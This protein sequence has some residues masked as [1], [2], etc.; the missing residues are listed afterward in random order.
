MAEATDRPQIPPDA[1]LS[2]E[3]LGVPPPTPTQTYQPLS[4]LA[5][6]GFGLA[7]VYALVVLI[8]GAVSLLSHKPWLMPYWTF[9]L[10]IAVLF[11]SW[12][13]RTRILNSEGTLSGLAFTTWG[14]RLAIFLSI[15]YAAYLFA[16]F[17]A[18]RGSAIDCANDFFQ[19]I[20][21]G[22]LEEAFL[23][24]QENVSIKGLDASAMRDLIEARFN[25][26]SGAVAITP[27]N[28]TRFRQENFI[29]LIEM[30]GDKANVTPTGVAFWEYGKGGYRVVL[31]YHV[32]TSLVEFDMKVDTF[33][34]DPKPGESKPRQWQVLLARSETGTI[35]NSLTRTK[36]GEEFEKQSIN[37]QKFAA[38]WA[39]KIE[40]AKALKPAQRESY[41]KLIRGYETFWASD[42]LRKEISETIRKTF[43]PRAGG[44]NRFNLS[45]PPTGVPFLRESNGRTTA[46]LD[47]IL[48]YHEE[49]NEM[50]L[51]LVNGQLVLSADSSEAANS[52]SAWRID[53]IEI[54]SGRTAPARQ[55]MQRNFPAPPADEADPENGR[56]AP[57]KP[58]APPNGP[59]GGSQKP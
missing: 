29:R 42:R 43:Q 34:R 19:R 2:G 6:A 50:P 32:A 5:M 47:M 13:A 14:S 45:F 16:T 17:L 26:P 46:R 24:S 37:A 54:E 21:A 12:A 28:F 30:D 59:A 56:K 36:Q 25:Q 51:Y 53:A 41:S 1:V 27:G 48:R 57:P 22:R 35:P 58:P 8:G 18:V 31:I 10:P 9:L 55:R 4:L 20:K 44:S 15:P 52:P 11:V 23:M 49:G 38:D 40:D 7:I 33:G 39:S 3:S